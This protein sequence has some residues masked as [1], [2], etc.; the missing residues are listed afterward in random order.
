MSW[1]LSPASADGKYTLAQVLAAWKNDAW[2]SD[3]TNMDPLVFIISAFRNRQRLMDY[4]FQGR[5]MVAIKRGNR[6]ALVPE[7][8]SA[9]VEILAKRHLLGK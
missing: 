9:R 4:I 3:P 1:K 6:W 8:C 5:T 7:D 2:H